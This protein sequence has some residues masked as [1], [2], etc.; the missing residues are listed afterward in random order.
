MKFH[1]AFE[2]TFTIMHYG[3]F[4][5]LKEQLRQGF[6]SQFALQPKHQ[7]CSCTWS[8]Q[9]CWPLDAAHLKS[10]LEIHCSQGPCHPDTG[11]QERRRGKR[12]STTWAKSAAAALVI[13]ELHNV[14]KLH[15]QTSTNSETRKALKGKDILQCNFQGEY[16]DMEKWFW[17]R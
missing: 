14:W 9:V 1:S 13:R 7:F 8:V 4:S 6:W 11:E 5:C 15:T 2:E 12:I 10:C 17:F 16:I 3:I